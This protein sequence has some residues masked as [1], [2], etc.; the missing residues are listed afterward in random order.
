[1]L[2]AI[3]SFV[4]IITEFVDRYRDKAILLGIMQPVAAAAFPILHVL[5]NGLHTLK[6]IDL[7]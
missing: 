3:D 4:A 5:M 6:F 1:M 7:I 2:A